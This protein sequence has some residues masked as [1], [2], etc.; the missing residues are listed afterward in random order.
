MVKEEYIK[1]QLTALIK[2]VYDSFSVKKI[3]CGNRQ[4]QH[5]QMNWNVKR[6][7]KRMNP[8]PLST[9]LTCAQKNSLH[10]NNEVNYDQNQMEKKKKTHPFYRPNPILIQDHHWHI[11]SRSL[12]LTEKI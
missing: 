9:V 8:E 7:L 6:E 10:K 11:H 1:C 2:G 5:L 3:P 12:R 4:E